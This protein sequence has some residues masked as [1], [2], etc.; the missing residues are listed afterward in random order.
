MT[1]CG[2]S[3]MI[4]STIAGP[5]SRRLP[6]GGAAPARAGTSETR[7]MPDG[8]APDAVVARLVAAGCIAA[9]AEAAELAAAAP[10]GAALEAMVRRREDGEPP[11]WITGVTTFAGRRLL[12]DR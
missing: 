10:D 2:R 3:A 1:T 9:E 12:V 8:P 5:R 11:A 7:A 4:R 6:W